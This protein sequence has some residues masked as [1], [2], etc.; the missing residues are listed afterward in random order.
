MK[1]TPAPK[2]KCKK[3]FKKFMPKFKIT[4]NSFFDKIK[5]KIKIILERDLKNFI[6]EIFIFFFIL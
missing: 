1:S 5:I 3:K 4:K 2:K 6:I